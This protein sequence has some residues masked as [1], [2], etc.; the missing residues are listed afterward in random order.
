MSWKGCYMKLAHISDL[1]IG[2]Y[3]KGYSLLEDQRYI[4]KQ[5]VQ[6]LGEVQPDALLIAGDIYDKA[7][8]SGEAFSLFDDF[9][10][11][12]DELPG[13]MQVVIIAGNHDSPE[14]LNFASSFLERHH[15]VISAMPPREREEHLKK[16]TLQ[17]SYGNLNLYLLPFTKPGDLKGRGL[18]S[19]EECIRSYQDAVQILLNRESIDWKERNVLVS[20]QFYQGG[21]HVT[22]VC[23]S[24]LASLQ[25]G[26]LE[27]ID[28]A[29]VKE[30]DYVALGHIHKAQTAG[31]PNVRYS[32]TPLK[33]SVSEVSHQ[34]SI[35]LVTIE[36]KGV[37]IGIQEL[38][39]TPLREVREEKGTLE[40]V[41]GRITEENR[42]DYFSITLT[43]E[44]ELHRPKEALEYQLSHLL[45]LRFENA[46]TREFLGSVQE[47]EQ[48]L[49]PKDAFAQFFQ[50]MQNRS[51]KEEEM[52]VMDMVFQQVL[53]EE[54]E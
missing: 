8:P 49:H 38:M 2:K 18:V 30:F 51:L 21:N 15:I 35:T 54:A 12:L 39:L 1:H 29:I 53:G 17:D 36:E 3:L 22:Q 44:G 11:W 25:V 24:E 46:R 45:E 31:Y 27:V 52:A 37:P 42:E 14:R 20:H 43:D 34:K 16:I 48:V 40:E 32:G 5:I 26:G 4:L 9:L 50:Q 19:E 28:S 23:D 7:A 33:Y 41:R 6:K 13:T 10:G 47:E